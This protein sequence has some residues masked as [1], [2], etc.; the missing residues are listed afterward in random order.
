MNWAVQ[1]NGQPNPVD[2][3]TFNRTIFGTSLEVLL[4]KST[5]TVADAQEVHL[6]RVHLAYTMDPANTFKESEMTMLTE[7]GFIFAVMRNFRGPRNGIP[8]QQPNVYK[9][10]TVQVDFWSYWWCES[11]ILRSPLSSTAN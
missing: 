11:S 7:I 5:M 3:H 1:P 9:D 4:G 8:K 2:N 10:Q 6:N